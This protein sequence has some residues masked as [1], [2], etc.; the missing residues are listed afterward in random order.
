[1]SVI[2]I[3][4]LPD[5][6][7]VKFGPAEA[8]ASVILATDRTVRNNAGIRLSLSGD[9]H[10]LKEINRRNQID[11]YPLTP[12][13][14][15]DHCD[16]DLSNAFWLKGIDQHGDVVLCHAVRLYALRQD[17][18]TA[19][20]DLSFYFDDGERAKT[21]GVHTAVSARAAAMS[22]RLAYSGALWVRSDFRGFGLARLIPPLS[23]T[24]SLTQWYPANHACFLTQPTVEKGMASVYGYDN[25]EY[26][27][28]L[29][30]LPG[31]PPT[32]N[33]AL[34]WKN[35]EDVNDEIKTQALRLN[36]SVG[37][38]LEGQRGHEAHL[39]V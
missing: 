18:K 11:W 29:G 4:R 21:A 38:G 34:C 3:P 17:L 22:G 8:V 26:S 31:F 13:F 6:V 30:N 36:Q 37:I 2:K 7:D 32:L 9:F 19:I 1:M 33:T 20:E 28:V 24:L 10:E 16:L 15:P 25:L 39:V 14:D 35:A 23:R 5:Q 12:N 27:I